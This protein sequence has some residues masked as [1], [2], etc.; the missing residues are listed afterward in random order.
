MR[1][2]MRAVVSVLAALVA[3]GCASDAGVKPVEAPESATVPVAVVAA[4]SPWASVTEAVASIHPTKGN[5]ANGWVR[6]SQVA[7]GVRV[8]AE[9]E[10]LKPSTK[11]AFHIHEFG[12]CTGA[13]GKTAGGH[14][15]PEGHPHA[16][17]DSEMHHAGDLGN[18]VTDAKGQA[19][20]DR[21]ISG[22]TIAGDQDPIVGRGVVIHA[23][24]DDLATQPSGTT[25]EGAT[26]IACGTIGIAKPAAPAPAK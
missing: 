26:R 18:L 7:G 3:A 11:H 4:P 16:G 24:E 23:G 8:T 14:Y 25:P 1:V 17:P 5:H 6:F 15:N 10:G 19:K 13:D 9:I 21:V 2:S 20:Y 12:D 22:L